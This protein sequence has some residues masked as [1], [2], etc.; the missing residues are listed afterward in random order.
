MNC[1][2]LGS[3][4]LWILHDVDQVD[5]ALALGLEGEQELVVYSR[6]NAGSS[7]PL[8]TRGGLME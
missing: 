3:D 1:T 8:F 2:Y 7:F 4:C 5:L 6:I